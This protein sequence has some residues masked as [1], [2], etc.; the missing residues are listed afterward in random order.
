MLL[1]DFKEILL[2]QQKILFIVVIA[3]IIDFITG[4]TKAIYTHNIQ[5]EKL[6]KT[7]PKIIGYFAVILI[8]ACLEIVF[9][10]SFITN[11][12]CTFI[13]IIEFISVIENIKYYVTVPKFLIKF[14]ND[15]KKELDSMTIEEDN[16]E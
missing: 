3:I 15:K 1:T 14:L 2:S 12:L 8:G 13:V 11:I 7:I 16:N 9:N 6:R 10:I 5:S 4:I